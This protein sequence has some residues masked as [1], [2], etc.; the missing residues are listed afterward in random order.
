MHYTIGAC[1]LKLVATVVLPAVASI[2]SFWKTI[3]IVSTICVAAA[4]Y[5]TP[6]RPPFVSF[7]VNV[8]A[9]LP[10]AQNKLALRVKMKE[11]ITLLAS[12]SPPN[13]K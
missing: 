6:V 8:V 12:L 13:R 5:D 10:S 2:S 3:P 4:P 11:A 9:T 7:Q 1:E